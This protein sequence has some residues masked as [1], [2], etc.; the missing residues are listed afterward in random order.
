MANTIRAWT[1]AGLL[2]GAAAWGLATVA[3]SSAD[4]PRFLGPGQDSTSAETGLLLDWPEGGPPEVWRKRLGPSFSPP[5]VAKGTLIAFHRIGND[6][7]IEAVDARTGKTR[8]EFRY[9]T[10]YKDRY[11]YNGGPRSSPTIDAGCVYTYGAEGTLTCLDLATGRKV[12]QRALNKD[13]KAPQAFFGVGVPPVV[14]G[15]VVLLNPGGPDGAGIVGI[16]KATGEVIWKATDHGASY[17]APVVRTVNGR[18]LAFF[19]TAEGLVILEPPTGK[20]IHTYPFRSVYR[21]SVNAASPVVVGDVVMLSAAYRVGSAALQVTPEGLL[22]LWRDKENLQNHWATSIHHEGFLYGV[23]GR[24]EEE[25]TMRCVDWN[26]GI[27]MWTGPRGLGRMI[28]ILVEGHLLA[29][30]E[31]GHLVLI[32][33]NCERYVQKQCVKVLDP[34]CWAPPVLA[35]GR[36]YLRNE[37]VLI[38][39]DLRAPKPPVAPDAGHGATG[40]S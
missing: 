10:R 35:N 3:A 18:R 7:V 17:S 23:D 24:H 38:C 36:V 25:A 26:S 12:W 9:P 16:A 4:W 32:E 14:D 19:L 28:S 22:P 13:V 40:D 2:A 11:R 29:M 8:W 15:D 1:I 33:A 5:V 21:E 6:E 37:T 27:V 31:R 20:V 34:P 39:L 30:A